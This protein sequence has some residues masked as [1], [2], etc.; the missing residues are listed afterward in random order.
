MCYPCAELYCE[1]M[2][3]PGRGLGNELVMDAG[4]MKPA[5]ESEKNK[6]VF[7]KGTFSSTMNNYHRVK[8]W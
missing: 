6:T 5:R 7:K 2:W 4:K 1:W 8:I 3:T